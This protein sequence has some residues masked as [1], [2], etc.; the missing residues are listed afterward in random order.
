KSKHHEMPGDAL[1][2]IAHDHLAMAGKRDRLDRKSGL[3]GDLPVHRLNQ[4][5]ANLYDAARQ[6]IDAVCGSARPPHDQHLAVA[7]DGG[8]D[9]QERPVRK[10]ARI[11]AH[12]VRIAST[13]ACD[14]ASPRRSPGVSARP[15]I[16]KFARPISALSPAAVSSAICAMPRAGRSI[17]SAEEAANTSA[18]MRSQ[19]ESN[20]TRVI[21]SARSYAA[22]INSR[23][24]NCERR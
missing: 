11:M 17:A 8:A 24:F 23:C 5:L 22:I 13:A 19:I 6:R 20:G 12:A 18:F 3:L 16:R 1:L 4:G 15:W 2:C 14:S 21:G 7:P 9:R 10:R